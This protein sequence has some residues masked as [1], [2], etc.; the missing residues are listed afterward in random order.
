MNRIS[1]L[2]I[3]LL[4]FFGIVGG[5]LLILVVSYILQG[6]R[7]AETGQFKGSIFFKCI[8]SVAI[9]GGLYGA[10]S[11]TYSTQ[12]RQEWWIAIILAAVAFMAVAYW[13]RTI[14]TGHTGIA[15]SRFLGLGKRKLQWRD[16]D[17]FNEDTDGGS[18][19]VFAKSGK[20]IRFTPFHV[21]FNEFLS[22]LKDHC[23][24]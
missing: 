7:A 14:T 17:Y 22:T 11:V 21:G 6:K 2:A 16:V 5:T 12:M 9:V 8:F 1:E 24:E 13:P 10:A 4:M 23:R 19:T 20:R 18:V 15:Q 3:R